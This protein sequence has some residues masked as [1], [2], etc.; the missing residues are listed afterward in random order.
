MAKI[1]CALYPDVGG[2]ESPEVRSR[3]YPSGYPDGQTLPTP[4]ANGVTPGGSGR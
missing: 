1:L 3:R 2:R 4:E